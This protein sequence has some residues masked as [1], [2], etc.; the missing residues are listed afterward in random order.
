MGEIA[1]KAYEAAGG[2]AAGGP[3]GPGAPSAGGAAGK[4]ENKGGKQD[5]VIDA[6]FEEG[7]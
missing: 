7:N 3:G 1:A 4:P 5:E 2:D 6:E